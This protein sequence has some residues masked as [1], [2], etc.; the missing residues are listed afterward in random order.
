VD[1]QLDAIG[2]PANA[3]FRKQ[4]T[5]HLQEAWIKSY[6]DV[7]ERLGWHF[8]AAQN[9]VK[10]R[11]HDEIH[12]KDFAF[13]DVSTVYWYLLHKLGIRP[14]RKVTARVIAE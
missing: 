3:H 6:K 7:C 11:W 4:I 14:S 2:A 8:V 1:K 5:S 10:G 13:Y 12:P 9:L